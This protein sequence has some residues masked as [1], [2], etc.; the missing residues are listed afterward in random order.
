MT[1]RQQDQA[2]VERMRRENLEAANRQRKP[3]L[4]LSRLTNSPSERA[5]HASRDPLMRLHAWNRGVQAGT[6]AVTPPTAGD[7]PS[8][9]VIV[10]D[11]AADALTVIGPDN[12]VKAHVKPFMGLA[13]CKCCGGYH[14]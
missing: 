9:S 13:K 8:G 6:M 2:N 4:A 3:R 7:I 10:Y 14:G 1:P 12:E 5:G 11:Q